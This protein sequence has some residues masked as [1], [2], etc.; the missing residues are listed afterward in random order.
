MA[1][2]RAAEY[3]AVVGKAGV[4]SEAVMVPAAEATATAATAAVAGGRASRRVL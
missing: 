4:G 1:D 2:V 3:E